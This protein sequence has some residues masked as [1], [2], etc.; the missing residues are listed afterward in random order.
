MCCSLRQ[1]HTRRD[2]DSHDALYV[3]LPP[4]NSLFRLYDA[5]TY[6]RH[7]DHRTDGENRREEP[8]TL[9]HRGV[10]EHGDA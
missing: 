7:D 10:A 6:V 1:E 4:E 8:H 9:S 3:D 5:H 2:K